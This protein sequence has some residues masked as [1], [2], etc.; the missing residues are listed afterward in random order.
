MYICKRSAPTQATF[1]NILEN[2]RNTI[3]T[4]EDWNLLMSRTDFFLSPDELYPFKA[5]MH[6]FVT[7]QLIALHIQQMLKS[8]HTPI[9]LSNVEHNNSHVPSAVEDD[10]LERT[11]LL[12]SGQRVML[13]SNLWV[14][15][16]LV[17]GSLGEI[18]TIFYT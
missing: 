7:N 14:S 12:C 17:N 16:R 6:L 13:T 11:V 1:K 8:L 3:A 10:Q 15:A 18:V 5:S 2:I 9:A 4:L